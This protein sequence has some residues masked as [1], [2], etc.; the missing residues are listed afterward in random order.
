M[1]P[2]FLYSCIFLKCLR[3]LGCHN[4]LI[5]G[6]SALVHLPK[7][8]QLIL[9]LVHLVLPLPDPGAIA[10]ICGAEMKCHLPIHISI[11]RHQGYAISESSQVQALILHSTVG[12]LRAKSLKQNL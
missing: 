6:F 3:N 4:E 7:A 5:Y 12:P 11:D 10:L 8:S 1:S 9:S 2:D